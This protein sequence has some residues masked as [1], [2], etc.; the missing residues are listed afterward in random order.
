MQRSRLSPSPY[1]STTKIMKA[2]NCKRLR[3]AVVFLCCTMCLFVMASQ[4]VRPPALDDLVGAWFGLDENRL[5]FCRLELN[6]NGKGLCSTI[7]VEDA[8]NLYVIKRW[9]LDGAN[10][11]FDLDAVDK[12]AEPIR[13]AGLANRKE[14]ELKISGVNLNW[15]RKITLFSEKRWLS[16][17]E[18]ARKRMEKYANEMKRQ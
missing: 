6:S 16:K 12:D 13:I 10:L 9:T 15:S 14:L 17:N 2:K 4:P 11:T 3:R 1:D 18:Q 7:D 8:P 5:I